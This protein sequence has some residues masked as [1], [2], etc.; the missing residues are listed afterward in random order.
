VLGSI[1]NASEAISQKYCNPAQNLLQTYLKLFGQVENIRPIIY[2]ILCEGSVDGS[3]KI[4]KYRLVDGSNIEAITPIQSQSDTSPDLTEVDTKADRLVQMITKSC[5]DKEVSA[6]F[7]SLMRRWVRAMEEQGKPTI[8]TTSPDKVS[9]SPIQDLAEATVLQ[10]LMELS[11]EQLVGNFDQ[12]VEIICQ[13]LKGD[14][15]TPLGDDLISV[16]LSLLNLVVTASSFQR[17]DINPQDLR[18][19]EDSLDRIGTSGSPDV[20][21]T[22]KNLGMLLKYRDEVE[23]GSKATP[24]APSIRQIEDKRTYNL[25]MSYVTGDGDNPPP[26]V[27][28]GLNMLSTLILAESPI[29]DITATTVLMS[30]LLRNNEDYIIARV[31]KMFTQLAS[32]HPNS[33]IRELLDNYL[34]PQEKLATDVR[35]RFGE[36]LVQ[37]IE[38]LGETFSGN[39]AQQTS[40]TLLAIASRRGYRPKTMARQAREEKLAALKE[41]R[42]SKSGD[43]DDGDM[44][45]GDDEQ[46]TQ[47]EQANNDIMARILQGWE[48]KRGSEDV[49]MRASALS[50][51]GVALETSLVGIGPSL[52]SNA[53]DLGINVLVLE[54]DVEYGI[55]RRAAIRVILS[56]VKALSEAREDGRSLGFGLTDASREDIQRTLHYVA[57][58]DNDG[59]VQEYARDVVETLDHWRAI[60]ML[61]QTKDRGA[62]GL[63]SLAGLTVN[64]E[65]SA[66]Q[67][68]PR[69]EEVE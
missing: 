43:D 7:L 44:D 22:A 31:V 39:V 64:P 52:V 54:R 4:W 17:S 19:I 47:E 41:A 35:L 59:V 16:V 30:N 66:Q 25:A 58:T 50:I 46:V 34:D 56:F 27:S 37:V 68:R 48:S 32:K 62:G 45:L 65:A 51:F 1:S 20:S 36:A 63:T 6:L 55:L 26:V 14:D 28:E 69:I 61:P 53:V 21:G 42:A 38:R 15:S 11:P 57:D 12:L 23:P 29:L 60:N 49:R 9:A 33:T 67:P 13:I 40:E 18:L 3:S 24:G 10:K 2:N 8:K 5:T